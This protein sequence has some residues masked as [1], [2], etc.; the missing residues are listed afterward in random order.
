MVERPRRFQRREPAGPA[1]PVGRSEVEGGSTEVIRS[2]S[3]SGPNC[4]T[5]RLHPW[6]NA[7]TAT[8]PR[9]AG[10]GPKPR[11][12]FA[13]N[14][15]PRGAQSSRNS[16][17]TASVDVVPDPFA[18]SRRPLATSPR[19]IP[20]RGRHLPRA[21]RRGTSE[22]EGPLTGRRLQGFCPES[23]LR[24]P[25]QVLRAGTVRRELKQ[26]ISI[27]MPGGVARPRGAFAR[28]APGSPPERLPES[29]SGGGARGRTHRQLLR[30]ESALAGRGHHRRDPDS[31]PPNEQRY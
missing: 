20:R 21:V 3:S 14:R 2:S 16:F 12:S 7:A 18:R 23:G 31:G 6:S 9:D 11:G 1:V 22:P 15:R 13:V 25:P 5:R 24:P 4:R 29:W 26:A 27:W 8:V 17:V 19:S 28:P 10:S 30:S